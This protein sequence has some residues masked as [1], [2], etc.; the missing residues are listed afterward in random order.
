M[1]R[2]HWLTLLAAL[3]LCALLPAVALAD[4]KYQVN[5][6]ARGGTTYSFW[7]VS[8]GQATLKLTQNEGKARGWYVLAG[9]GGLDG[10][11]GMIGSDSEYGYYN[12]RIYDCDGYEDHKWGGRS[13]CT[14][15]FSMPG[16]YRVDIMPYTNTQMESI[17]GEGWMYWESYPTWKVSNVTRCGV[18]PRMQ[19]TITVKHVDQDTGALLAQEDRVYTTGGAPSMTLYARDFS[20]Y[21]VVGGSSSY[22]YFDDNGLPAINGH[23]FYYRKANVQTS[24]CVEG[25]DRSNGSLIYSKTYHISVGTFT[26]DAPSIDGYTVSGTR[27][28]TVRLTQSGTLTPGSTITF[29]YNRNGSS[30]SSGGQSG[31]S[32][33]YRRSSFYTGNYVTFGRFEQDG[34][35]GDGSENIVWLVLESNGS[36]AM[37]LAVNGLHAIAYHQNLAYDFV[38]WSDCTLRV[39]LNN[40]FLWNAFTNDE[41]AAIRTTTVSTPWMDEFSAWPGSATQD[42]VFILSYQ[43]VE[44]YLGDWSAWPTQYAINGGALVNANKGGTTYW[45]LRSPNEPGKVSIINSSGHLWP[46]NMGDGDGTVRPVIWVDL[47]NPIF[48]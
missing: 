26:L 39:W 5:G 32:G 9:E 12:I 45:W 4:T 1:K 34:N 47:T 19:H 11:A 15:N 16:T 30:S 8:K 6:E 27:S 41:R 17:F 23:T 24:I 43:E 25:R 33:Q 18:H 22:V 13:S 48:Y 42:K 29:Y 35:R 2:S 7:V 14:L 3:L 21:E 40:T 20:G 36:R 38:P 44:R 28:V 31:S 46:S 10:L 37:L